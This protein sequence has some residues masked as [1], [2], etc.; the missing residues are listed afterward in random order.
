MKTTP[1]TLRPDHRYIKIKIDD[2]EPKDFSQTVELIE[3]TVRKFSGDKGLA[4]VS[5][6]LLKGLFQ[7]QNQQAVVRVRKEYENLFKASI[8]VSKTRIY[9]VKV[10]G[11]QES[12]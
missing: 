4:Q 6:K 11:T 3:N 2:E 5:P 12:L 9:T 10:S 7:F 1:K 8:A